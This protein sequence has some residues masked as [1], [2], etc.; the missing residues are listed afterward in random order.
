MPI[1]AERAA[2]YPKN[3]KQIRAAILERAGHACEGSP[4][5]PKCRAVNYEPHPETGSKV[6]LTIAHLDHDETISDPERLRAF[7]QRCH[8]TYD[9]AHHAKN[10]A[11]TRRRKKAQFDLFAGEAT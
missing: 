10:A 9:A 8:L 11:E 7:C 4:R 1:R 3:W 6:V 2:L 5:F